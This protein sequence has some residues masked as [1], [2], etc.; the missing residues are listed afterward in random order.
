MSPHPPDKQV[1]EP[2]ERVLVHG[3]HQGKVGDAEEQQRGA[4]GDGAVQLTRLVD[5]LFRDFS[6]SD[7][8]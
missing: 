8:G 7:L 5:L 6:L 3:V 1:D 4:Q 2:G